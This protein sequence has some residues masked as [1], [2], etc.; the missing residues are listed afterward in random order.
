MGLNEGTEISGKYLASFLISGNWEM[1][2]PFLEEGLLTIALS[3]LKTNQTIKKIHMFGDN[4]FHYS[5]NITRGLD[6]F[7]HFN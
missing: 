5:L 4:I 1:E 2:G 6:V 7:L 3:G